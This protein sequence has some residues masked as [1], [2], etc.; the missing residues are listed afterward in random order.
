MIQADWAKIGVK[1]RIVTYEWGEYLRRIRDGDAPVGMLGEI[2]DYPDP[3]EI[4]LSFLCGAPA[5]APHF[6]SDV[7]DKAVRAANLTTDRDTRARLYE[8]AQQAMYDDVPL[9]RLADVRAYVA[10]RKNV[11][12]FRPSVLGSQP[13]GGVSLGR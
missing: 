8:Q 11:Q 10:L 2:W 5:N 4:M 3:S 1:A 6:C 7:Y 9:V 13:Y 12:G